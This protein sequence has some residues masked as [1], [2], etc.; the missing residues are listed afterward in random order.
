MPVLPSSG[1]P[2]WG[3]LVEGQF[4]QNGQKPHENDEIGIFG[5]K[6]WGEGGHGGQV[7]FSGIGG[8]SPLSP[9]H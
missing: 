8:G 5:S 3:R 1:F 7:N 6:Q 9:P 2:N 4:G